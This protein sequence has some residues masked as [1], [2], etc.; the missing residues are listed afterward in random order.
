MRKLLN[1]FRVLLENDLTTV[2][3]N[4]SDFKTADEINNQIDIIHQQIIKESDPYKIADY[5]S[6]VR[7]LKKWRKNLIG[8]NN[9]N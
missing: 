1:Q 8:D 3:L 5:N 4:R 9:E 2:A 6:D 7:L